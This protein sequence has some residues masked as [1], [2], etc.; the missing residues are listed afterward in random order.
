M[1]ILHHPEFIDDTAFVAPNAMVIGEVR[2]AAQASIWFGCVLRGD[3]E[4]ISIGPR[5]NVQ[6][7][8][9]IHTD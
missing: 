8:S 6:D 3:N 2:I 1:D 7:L 4:P 5:T 9:V